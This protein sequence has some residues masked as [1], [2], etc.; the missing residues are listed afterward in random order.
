M[1]LSEDKAES[2]GGEAIL[3]RGYH[4]DRPLLWILGPF[5]REGF[6]IRACKLRMSEAQK[7]ELE[8]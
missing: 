7:T 4:R 2:L 1:V 3:A 5:R 6:H 8:L